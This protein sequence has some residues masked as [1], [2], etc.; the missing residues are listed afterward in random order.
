MQTH[1]LAGHQKINGEIGRPFIKMQGLGNHFVVVDGRS[2]PFRPSAGEIIRICDEKF[3][4]GAEQLLVIES[5]TDE[6]KQLGAD[7]RMRIYNPDGQEAQAC[8]NAT[9][10]VIHLLLEEAAADE[11]SL[12]TMAG[13][14]K[15]QR[16]GEFTVSVN[17]GRIYTEWNRIPV[18][19]PLDT[20]HA[21]VE[22]GPLHDAT[23]LNIGNPHAVFFVDDLDSVDLE[24]FGPAVQA[25]PLFP[26]SVNVGAA[27]FVDENTL[28]LSV[29]ERPGV[30]TT[31]CGSGSCVAVYA[32]HARGLTAARK[33]TV[34]MAGGS[35]EVQLNDDGT[36]TM[37]GPVAYSFRGTL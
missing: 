23:L 21:H 8:G 2:T 36:A 30:L 31:G 37:T 13:V 28:R 29:Y 27:E 7:A 3:G 16:V 33:M 5:P 17:M 10:C 35:I 4:V 22:S 18:S 32:A 20:L 15:G 24:R 19:R 1:D 26:E 12:E 9:R 25:N 34:H 11:L 14:L 6:A